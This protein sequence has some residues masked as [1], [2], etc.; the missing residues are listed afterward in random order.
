MKMHG[1]KKAASLVLSLMMVLGLC[2]TVN[3]IQ[4]KAAAGGKLTIDASGVEDLTRVRP[5]DTVTITVSLADNEEAVGVG[6]KFVYDPS[7]LELQE[8]DGAKKVTEGEVYQSTAAFIKDLN[9]DNEGEITSMVLNEVRGSDTVPSVN[10]EVFTAVFTVKAAAKGSVNLQIQELD[11][12]NMDYENVD[13][14]VVNHASSMN[15]IVP[16]TGISLN[17]ESIE[18]TK[19]A[20]EQLNAA[21]EPADA[22][23]PIVWTSSDENV[24]TVASDG[25]VTAVGKGTATVTASADGKSASCTVHVTVPLEGIAI[26][27]TGSNG[28]TSDTGLTIGKGRTATLSVSYTP[29]DADAGTVSWESSDPSKVTVE[30][31]GA[32]TAV[33]KGLANTDEDPV[34]ITAKIGAISDTFTISVQEIKMT[35]LAIKSETIIHRGEEEILNVTYEPEDTTDDPTVSWSSSAPEVVA[36]DENGKVTAKAIG[37]AE[38]TA[39]AGEF[40]ATCTVTVDAPLK[41]IVPSETSIEL[42]KGQSKTITYTLNPADTTSDKK[43]TFASD[44]EAAAVVDPLTGEVTAKAEGVATITLTGA[45]GVTAMVRVTVKG[46]AANGTQSGGNTTTTPS[47]SGNRPATGDMSNA[48][49]YLGLMFASLAT[50]SF[51]F[52]RRSRK[53]RR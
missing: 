18:L 34:T 17:K 21:V 28:V 44:N 48:A 38:I 36:V 11:F 22:D 45:E 37:T 43:V 8:E 23:T 7:Q 51:L 13:C 2:F 42:E 19:G 32:N 41:E 1:I 16:V 5:G 24:A 27:G 40:T 20:A 53:V 31:T 30:S 14:E 4:V 26:T 9:F 33:V 29:T 39:V 10:G 3:P 47:G 49:G 25:T 52:V 6:F 35:G 12:V 50:I 15:V 46:N